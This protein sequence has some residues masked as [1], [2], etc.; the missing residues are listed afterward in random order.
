MNR[1]GGACV[2]QDHNDRAIAIGATLAHEMGHNLGMDH[3]DSGACACTGDSCVMAASLRWA[4]ALRWEGVGPGCGRG[5]TQM[6]LHSWNIPRT[7]SSCSSNNY[8]KFLLNRSPG[9]LLDP[10]DYRSLQTPPVCGNGFQEE[11]EQCDCGS[12]QVQVKGHGA[13]LCQVV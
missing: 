8:E 12:L 4:A 2:P 13:G 1:G 10:P 11:G 3:D 5:L 9:C 6:C 7:F